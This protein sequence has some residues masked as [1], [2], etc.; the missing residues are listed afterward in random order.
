MYFGV[1]WK[2]NFLWKWC[3]RSVMLPLNLYLMNDR[4]WVFSYFSFFSRFPIG[5]YCERKTRA[6]ERERTAEK[7][8][9]KRKGN[10]E[11]PCISIVMTS[12]LYFDLSPTVFF[13]R[14]RT[15]IDPFFPLEINTLWWSSSMMCE[16]L[17][18]FYLSLN[19]FFFSS[20]EM[21]IIIIIREWL[22]IITIRP[23]WINILFFFLL[24]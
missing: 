2:K 22:K 6:R 14:F 18:F 11:F 19:I 17:T 1:D 12:S 9:K 3:N 21:I 23:N 20:F 5:F 15:N 8:E 4:H 16:H 10:M 13:L 24:L 7:S